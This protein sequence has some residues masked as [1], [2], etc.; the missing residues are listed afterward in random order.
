M[1]TDKF[2]AALRY[3]LAN[4]GGF[5]DNPNDIGGATNFG[6]TYTS[7]SKFIGKPIT[8]DYLK[9]LTQDIVF[10]FYK[11]TFWVP[12]V[13][14]TFSLPVACALFDTAVNMGQITATKIAQRCLGSLL[15]DGILGDKTVQALQAVDEKL[16]L[17]KYIGALL[18][19]DIDICIKSYS[20]IVFLKGWTGRRLRLLTLI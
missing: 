2:E 6:I 14:D 13:C 5:V 15:S 10:D 16:F 12:M 1:P 8:L 18:N 3:V 17:S 7:L 11:K 19:Y 4:E 9:S 20:Q